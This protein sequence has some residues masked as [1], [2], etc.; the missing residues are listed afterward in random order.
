M[1]N[2]RTHEFAIRLA[3]GA[4]RTAIAAAVICSGAILILSGTTIGLA[5]AWGLTRFLS[6]LLFQVPPLDFLSVAAAFVCVAVVT[7]T[8]M[9]IPAHKAARVDPILALRSE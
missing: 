6:G 2:Q 9:S 8:A 4:S 5:G 7:V 3:V 1:A